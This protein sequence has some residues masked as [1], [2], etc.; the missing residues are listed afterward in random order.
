M[1][2][3]GAYFNILMQKKSPIYAWIVAECGNTSL[4]K[5]LSF[6]TRRRFKFHLLC[7]NL[8][9]HGVTRTRKKQQRPKAVLQIPTTE[10][11]NEP[12]LE[13]PE[14]DLR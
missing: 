8:L 11:D 2:V 13:K 10:N 6:P 12:D 5:T 4:H 7:R 3:T 9:W 14:R 1:H